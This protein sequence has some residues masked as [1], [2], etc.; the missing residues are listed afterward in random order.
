[1]KIVWKI[2][3]AV[4]GRNHKQG[5]SKVHSI[6]QVGPVAFT[7][8]RSKAIQIREALL[9]RLFLSELEKCCVISLELII[10]R[11]DC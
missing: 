10:I 7:S 3:Q 9:Y 11:R 5:G 4:K 1:M 6:M 2:L 8:P